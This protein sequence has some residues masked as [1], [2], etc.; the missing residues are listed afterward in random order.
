M[1][2]WNHR[3]VRRVHIGGDVEYAIHEAYYDTDDAGNKVC[4]GFT[5][6]PVDVSA[7]S[8]ESLLWILESMLAA[9]QKPVLDYQTRKEIHDAPNPE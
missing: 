5:M 7:V 3:V 4:T 8:K 9:L 1:S 2:N 6:E